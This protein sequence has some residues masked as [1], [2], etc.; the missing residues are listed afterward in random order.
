MIQ[1]WIRYTDKLKRE[2]QIGVL[3]QMG[4]KEKGQRTMVSS[5]RGEAAG[6]VRSCR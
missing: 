5:H 2:V 3:T 1:V 6:R 4:G